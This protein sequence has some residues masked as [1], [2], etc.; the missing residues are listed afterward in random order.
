[1]DERKSTEAV[2][3][4]LGGAE[5]VEDDDLLR[6]VDQDVW[7]LVEDLPVVAD[8]ILAAVA[9]DVAVEAGEGAIARR[10]ADSALLRSWC[11]SRRR[12]C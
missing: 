2:E 8:P 6:E 4:P 7:S 3:M 12:R 10:K 9:P 1:M 11:G 5:I